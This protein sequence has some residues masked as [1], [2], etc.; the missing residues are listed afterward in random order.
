MQEMI[1]RHDVQENLAAM[2]NTHSIKPIQLSERGGLTAIA[3]RIAKN[4]IEQ[5][6]MQALMGDIRGKILVANR[7]QSQ[8]Q[9][10]SQGRGGR[11]I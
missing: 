10:R 11:T 2:K 1:K 4:E 7:V 5:Q 9:D 6:D 8:E 3:E